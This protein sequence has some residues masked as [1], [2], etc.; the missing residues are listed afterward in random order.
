MSHGGENSDAQQRQR[1]AD[2]DEDRDGGRVAELLHLRDATE[3]QAVSASGL[4]L[5]LTDAP[6][7][8]NVR[9]KV[10]NHLLGESSISVFGT[11]E[12]ASK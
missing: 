6:I 5:L 4:D 10:F 8:H 12:L 9:V 2:H 7:G 1:R 11:K 3:E